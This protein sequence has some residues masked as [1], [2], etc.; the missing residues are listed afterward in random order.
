MLYEVDAAMLNTIFQFSIAGMGLQE[1]LALKAALN[2]MV[3]QTEKES[4]GLTDWLYLHRRTLY[5]K[6][7]SRTPKSPK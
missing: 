7:A 1:R 4:Y 2:F 3:T 5:P 6:T